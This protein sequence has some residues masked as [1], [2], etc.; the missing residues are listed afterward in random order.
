MISIVQTAQTEVK[1]HSLQMLTGLFHLSYSYN[2]FTHSMQ[3]FNS[4]EE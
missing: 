2:K 4:I 3:S 1:D